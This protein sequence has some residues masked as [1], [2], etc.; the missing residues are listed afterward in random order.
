MG[1]SGGTPAR[2]DQISAIAAELVRKHDEDGLS[3]QEAAL[4]MVREMFDQRMLVGL[5]RLHRP[6]PYPD[7]LWLHSHDVLRRMPRLRGTGAMVEERHDAPA[8][9][10]EPPPGPDFRWLQQV[11]LDIWLEWERLTAEEHLK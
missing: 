8:T 5:A 9:L 3:L 11:V 10:V 6:V 1:T 2:A 7:S 4:R